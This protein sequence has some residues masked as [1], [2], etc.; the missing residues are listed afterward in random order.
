MNNEPL[1]TSLCDPARPGFFFGC[2][3]P[4][5]GTTPDEARQVCKLF[6]ERSAVL[7]TDGFVVYD[8][9]D[10]GVRTAAPRPFPFRKT[11]DSA[12]FASYF[13][14]LSGKECIVYK[15]AMESTPADFDGWLQCAHDLGHRALNLVGAPSSRA[16]GGGLTLLS[17]AARVRARADGMRFGCVAIPE[18]HTSKGNEHENMGNKAAAGAE[19]VRPPA[20]RRYWGCG[21]GAPCTAHAPV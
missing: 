3:P 2:T 12:Q 17:A 4:R 14:P 9:Q 5:E 20:L 16:A 13:Q 8:I 19:W 18:R 1:T 10:E 21:A 7:A 6:A 11:M 15:C